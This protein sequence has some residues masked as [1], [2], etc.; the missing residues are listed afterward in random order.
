[1]KPNERLLAVRILTQ[2]LQEKKPLSHLLQTAPPFTKELCF[3]VC[4][5]YFALEALVTPLLKKRPKELEIWL[6][7]LL[8][9]YQLHYLHTPDYAVV[10]E[11]VALLEQLKKPWAKG[12]INAVLRNFC[13]QKETIISKIYDSPAYKHNH[14]RWLLQEIKTTWPAKWEAILR[15]NDAHPPMSLRVNN[16]RISTDAYLNRLQEAHI[17]AHKHPHAPACL[18]LA[19][20]CPVEKLPGFA[21]GDVSVQDAAAQMAALLLQLKPGLRLLD[22]C[23]APGGKTCHILESEPDLACCVAVDADLKRLERVQENLQRLHLQATLVA[24]D[25]SVPDAWWDGKPFDRILVDAPCSAT[26]VI[27]RHPDIKLL[28]TKNEVT[29][30]AKLQEKILDALWPLLAPGGL[31]VYATCS[32]LPEENE[33]QIARFID[34]HL[35]CKPLMHPHAWAHATGHG[36]QILPGEN[37]MDGFFYSVLSKQ[38]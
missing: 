13:R 28:R 31:M 33:Q 2:L 7:L 24:G 35:D 4:R 5:F 19:E 27:R 3:G 11:T 38:S 14:P 20:P 1:M 30:A 9:I 21:A 23:C 6:S 26:G 10:K 8:G 22:A 25:A 37:N 34:R 12:L 36:W 17:A 15:A 16:A 18:V 32:I 29:N